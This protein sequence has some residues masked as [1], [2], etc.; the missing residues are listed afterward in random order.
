MEAPQSREFLSSQYN[1]PRKTKKCSNNLFDFFVWFFLCFVVVTKF[2]LCVW[3]ISSCL[4]KTTQDVKAPT[5]KAEKRC[6][7]LTIVE[8]MVVIRLDG[9]SHSPPGVFSK[10]NY[11]KMK[12]TQVKYSFYPK[13]WEVFLEVVEKLP[14]ST[15]WS[16]D[17]VSSNFSE[18]LAP[19]PTFCLKYCEK[20]TPSPNVSSV[21]RL[22][23]KSDFTS[24][25]FGAIA[26]WCWNFTSSAVISV[27]ILMCI[28]AWCLTQNV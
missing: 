27:L 21:R 1:T 28:P 16:M 11:L 5:R 24:P 13:C 23:G 9:I 20:K 26:V 22:P 12:S 3:P 8:G 19:G 17:V 14:G 25:R 15:D 6:A 2:Q 18:I 7:R 4:K 10:E